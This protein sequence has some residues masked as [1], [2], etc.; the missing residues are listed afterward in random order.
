VVTCPDCR[1]RSK[2]AAHRHCS[3][4]L[5]FAAS[6]PSDSHLP[7]HHRK[8]FWTRRRTRFYTAAPQDVLVFLD[9]LFL[10]LSSLSPYLVVGEAGGSDGLDFGDRYVRNDLFKWSAW[11]WTWIVQG[12]V[13]FNKYSWE[14]Q[15]AAPK[16]RSSCDR[17][18]LVMLLVDVA[19]ACGSS[20][21]SG[22]R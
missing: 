19:V 4:S 2:L 21:C 5:T 13:I 3:F 12:K 17:W 16:D 15:R 1:L 10:S 18:L 6:P 11:T 20:I 14:A 22:Q 9:L 8:V 7:F